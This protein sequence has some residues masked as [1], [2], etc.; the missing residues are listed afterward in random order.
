MAFWLKRM[1]VLLLSNNMVH[2]LIGPVKVKL[3]ISVVIT[4]NGWLTLKTKKHPPEGQ[5][6]YQFRLLWLSRRFHIVQHVHYFLHVFGGSF[7]QCF[8]LTVQVQLDDLFDTGFAQYHW[9][10]EVDVFQA[11]FAGEPCANG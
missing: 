2:N 1:T 4:A 11:V 5:V 7:Q 9:N 8:F 3:R 10:A 6:L